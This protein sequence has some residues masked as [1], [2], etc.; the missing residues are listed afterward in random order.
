MLN[1]DKHIISKTKS[2][3]K[4]RSGRHIRPPWKYPNINMTKSKKKC[5][6]A[7]CGPGS[8]AKK[9]AKHKEN[10]NN[11]TKIRALEH[12]AAER[13]RN[14]STQDKVCLSAQELLDMITQYKMY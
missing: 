14:L 9:T 8:I 1:A 5:N 12:L 2:A 13:G 7:K 4:T 10:L 3:M 11:K 6:R